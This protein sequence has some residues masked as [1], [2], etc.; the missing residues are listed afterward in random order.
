MLWKGALSCPQHV[1][2]QNCCCHRCHE[3]TH[4]RAAVH[5]AHLHKSKV[6]A[7]VWRAVD[8]YTVQLAPLQVAMHWYSPAVHSGV[9]P[10][11][12]RLGDTVH[13]PND[14]VFLRSTTQPA[15]HLLDTSV[16][17]ASSRNSKQQE[18]VYRGTPR[19]TSEFSMSVFTS[20]Y[21]RSSDRQHNIP[22]SATR[23][24]YNHTMCLWQRLPC[25]LGVAHSTARDTSRCRLLA[26]QCLAF[27]TGSGFEQSLKAV[28]QTAGGR[29]PRRPGFV[30]RGEPPPGHIRLPLLP[31]G[32]ATLE[33]G[34]EPPPRAAQRRRHA[35]MHTP[36]FIHTHAPS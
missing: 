27:N 18:H 32:R 28:P 25:S 22:S 11:S 3:P 35:G 8:R 26:A 30:D 14:P 16:P 6:P 9:H 7:V 10:R 1:W 15:D 4:V 20:L 5:G 31:P 23:S 12:S 33:Q 24:V 17:A 21:S 19:T 36:S 2:S 13:K 29:L 34:G